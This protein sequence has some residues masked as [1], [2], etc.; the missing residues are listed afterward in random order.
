MRKVIS[1]WLF[2]CAFMV[3]IMIAIGGYTRLEGAGLSIVEWKPV[4]GI[5]LPKNETEWTMEFENYQRFPEY[6]QKNFNISLS[7]FKRIY[8]IEYLHRFLGRMIGLVFVIPLAFFALT[9]KITF[10]EIRYFSMIF[11]LGGAQGFMGWYMVSSGLV[12]DP[13]VSQYRLTAHLL[14]AILIYSLLVWQGLKFYN[15]TNKKTLSSSPHFTILT[16]LVMLQITLGGLL[17]GLHGGLIY[18]TFPLMDDKFIPPGLFFLSPIY[19]NFFENITMVQFLHRMLGMLIVCYS[20]YIAI[21]T[22]MKIFFALIV[23]QFLLGILTLLKL[24]PTHLAL[25]HQLL[26]IVLLT[27]LL[28]ILNNSYTHKLS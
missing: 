12:K 27:N 20:A 26:A 9:K 22:R 3:L 5:F 11:L 21:I 16:I 7:E 13:S 6:K 25:A 28:L 18:N 23:M 10:S 15:K 17:A 24:V 4:K 1:Y 2:L 19:L 8:L 14:M